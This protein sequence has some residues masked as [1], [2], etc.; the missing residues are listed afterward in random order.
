MD[1]ASVL[2]LKSESP[3]NFRLPDDVAED[4]GLKADN[5]A[6]VLPDVPGPHPDVPGPH[7]DVPRPQPL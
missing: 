4:P 6:G 2:F 5:V 7:P 1:K 3:S